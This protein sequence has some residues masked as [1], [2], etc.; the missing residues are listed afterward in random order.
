[1]TSPF[2]QLMKM[3]SSQ[4]WDAAYRNKNHHWVLELGNIGL[5]PKAFNN[6][7]HGALAGVH[8]DNNTE[9]TCMLL[10]LSSRRKNDAS[11]SQM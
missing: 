3:V 8:H 6:I 1:M 9:V 11:L 10:L 5:A 7:A 2:S 4:A